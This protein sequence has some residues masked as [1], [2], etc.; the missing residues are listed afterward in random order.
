MLIDNFSLHLIFFCVSTTPQY[1]I[2]D[3][4]SQS[5]VRRLDYQN[6]DHPLLT[7]HL[8]SIFLSHKQKAVTIFTYEFVNIKPNIM[9]THCWPLLKD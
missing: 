8:Q 7:R 2:E 1:I 9:I 4:A 3:H 6:H 5:I